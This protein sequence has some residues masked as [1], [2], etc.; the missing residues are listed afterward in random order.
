M[1]PQDKEVKELVAI[2]ANLSASEKYLSQAE[3]R[4]YQEAQASVVE[5]H[6]AAALA[7]AVLIG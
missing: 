3:R 6:R 7:P 5:A 4:R 2:V 1:D